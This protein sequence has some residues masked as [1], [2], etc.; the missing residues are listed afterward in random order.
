MALTPGTN[1]PLGSPCPDFHLPAVDG[2]KYRRDDFKDKQA[3]VVMFICNHCP[4]VMAVE[5]RLL[6]LQRE[7]EGKSVQ[8]VGICANDPTDYPEDSFENLKKRW[9]QKQYKFPYLHD[10]EQTVAKEFGAVCT[11]E[12]YVYGPDRKLAYH[13]RLDD[14][15][16][17][18]DKVT[19][20]EM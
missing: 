8:F 18:A 6:Q 2:K 14:N 3:L 11:P 4:Y 12:F 13:G 9:T 10:L 19:R 1:I 20:R 15:W 16:Q 5:D 7:Y 17:Q